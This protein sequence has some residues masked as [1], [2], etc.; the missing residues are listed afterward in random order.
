METQSYNLQKDFMDQIAKDWIIKNLPTRE[1]RLQI[2]HSKKFRDWTGVW[3]AGYY[4][5][6]ARVGAVMQATHLLDENSTPGDWVKVY[7]EEC[8]SFSE[9]L[10][11]VLEVSMKESITPEKALCAW[12]IH[13]IDGF[14]Q[15]RMAEILVFNACKEKIEGMHNGLSVREATNEEDCEFGIDLVVLNSCGEI[16]F[17]IQT[18]PI[19]YFLSNREH[20]IKHRNRDNPKKYSKFYRKTGKRV[21]YAIIEEA[22]RNGSDWHLKKAYHEGID[23]ANDF[24]YLKK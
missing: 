19:S 24:E 9:I 4:N 6:K 3:R 17:G 7:T 8:R 21:W 12:W 22:T 5:S 14:F 11:L 1:E 13:I 18:K 10:A 2:Q 16:E 15:G 23:D 20:V